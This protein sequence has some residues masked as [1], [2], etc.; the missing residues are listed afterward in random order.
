MAGYMTK[1]NGH[2]YEGG[3]AAGEALH[4]GEFVQLNASGEVVKTAAAKDMV[5]HCR[6]DGA[7]GDAG[8]CAERH[9]GWRG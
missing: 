6:E 4:N 2:V 9:R 3:H 7:L 5:P 8:R 1:L